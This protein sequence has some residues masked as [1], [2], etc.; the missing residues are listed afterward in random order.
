MSSELSEREEWVLNDGEVLERESTDDDA[1]VVEVET[2]LLVRL[3]SQLA[4][5]EA[6]IDE[7]EDR[8]ETLETAGSTSPID[9]AEDLT[10]LERYAQIPEEDREELISPSDRRAVAIFEHWWDLAEKTP[11]G[12]VVSTRRNSVKKNNPSQFKL[13]LEGACGEE[14]LEWMQVYRAM[15]HVAK[16]SG[17]EEHQNDYGRL[18]IHGGA[19]EYHEKTT[20]DGEKT[21]KVLR[22]TEDNSL[23][24][25]LAN[26]HA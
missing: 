16:L 18:H 22:L 13:D 5:A 10:T 1:D 21:Y 19:F 7:L 8:V 15:Q 12:Y 20:P 4:E 26:S 17:G 6:R 23:T 24:L 11:K 25:L 14:N 2:D 3:Q 9:D